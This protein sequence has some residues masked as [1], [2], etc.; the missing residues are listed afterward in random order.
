M[1][2]NTAGRRIYQV[3]VRDTNIYDGENCWE[4]NVQYRHYTNC[5]I[6]NDRSIVP[7]TLDIK[8]THPYF[9]LMHHWLQLLDDTRYCCYRCWCHVD[10]MLIPCWNYTLLLFL[11][12]TQVSTWNIN[13]W[14]LRFTDHMYRDKYTTINCM[15]LYIIS[16]SWT[17]KDNLRNLHQWI[18]G[19]TITTAYCVFSNAVHF[20]SFAVYDGNWHFFVSLLLQV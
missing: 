6:N 8:Q 16:T 19:R 13:Q 2:S 5:E 1:R 12:T 14:N 18:I 3:Q 17:E 15:Y 10:T 7:Q 11:L 9:I 4:E 20:S